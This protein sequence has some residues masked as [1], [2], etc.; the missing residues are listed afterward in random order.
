MNST[1]LIARVLTDAMVALAN[2]LI[3]ARAHVMVV[4]LMV[5]AIHVMVT[6]DK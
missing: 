5:A 1:V 6:Q 3:A 2:V 4:V